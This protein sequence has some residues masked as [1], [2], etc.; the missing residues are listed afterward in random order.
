MRLPYVLPIAALLLACSDDGLPAATDGV[1][2][3]GAPATASQSDSASG[4][5]LGTTSDDGVTPSGTATAGT[6]NP[7]SGGET[8]ENDSGIG[9]TGPA[10]STLARLY[11]SGGNAVS[12]WDL[13]QGDGSLTELQRLDQGSQVGSLANLGT[14]YMYAAR[15]L[16][17]QIATLAIDP[18]D[19][20]LTELATTP[21]GH[22]PVYLSVDTTQRWL[23]TADFDNNL[24]QVYPLGEDG[25]VGPTPSE[26]RT[27]QA[28]PHAILQD[29]SGAYVFVPHRDA[30]L[31]EQYIFDANSGTLIA[32]N[33]PSVAAPM[34]T[35]PR[36]MVFAP[37]A[38]QAYVADE[39][40]S[41]VTVYAYDSVSGTL[42][43]GDTF[44]GLSRGFMGNNTGADVHVTPDGAYV[45]ASMRGD[46]T[47]AMF[48]VSGTSLVSL[49]NVAT[50]PAPRDF[51]LGP[52][53]EYLYV[54]GQDSG[55]LASYTVEASGT[56][57]PGPIYDV[58]ATPLW[59]L[60]LELSL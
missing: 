8:S 43:Q 28:R 23:L 46:N 15:G 53:G 30:N 13:D 21:V 55:M 32:N 42:T 59:V 58:G 14:T 56:L 2:D 48:Q 44:N 6:A 3:G 9:T 24:V 36:H 7:S 19:G 38:S 39:F 1:L 12:V 33:P 37:D 40:G 27:V 11:V 4:P 29:P 25:I 18:L 60:G 52:L 57:T 17:Q 47:I 22:I 51:G 35:G 31:I 20:T 10:P 41:S 26:N 34:G 50:E 54:A 5:P 45:Y 49:G 16:Q